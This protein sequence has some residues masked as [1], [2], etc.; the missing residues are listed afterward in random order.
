V[1]RSD[2]GAGLEAVVVTVADPDTPAETAAM[3]GNDE[4]A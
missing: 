4:A 3:R 1:G 2:V